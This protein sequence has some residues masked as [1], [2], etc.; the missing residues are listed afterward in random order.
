M[1]DDNEKLKEIGQD[2]IMFMLEEP[3]N[4]DIVNSHHYYERQGAC[5]DTEM[6]QHS[7][8]AYVIRCWSFSKIG[9]ISSKRRLKK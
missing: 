6:V 2:E 3:G 5:I 7:E 4:R 8:E 1:L 9:H